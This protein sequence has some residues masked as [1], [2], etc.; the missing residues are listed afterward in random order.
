MKSSRQFQ[1]THPR[2]VR[3]KTGVAVGR[4][5]G[6]F[7]S[8]TLVG[9]DIPQVPIAGSMFKFQFTHPHGVLRSG[10]R[11]QVGV[12]RFQ[13]T[14]PRGVR[15]GASLI[16]SLTPTVSI[17]APSWGATRP[18]GTQIV[19]RSFQFTHPRGVRLVRSA[20]S[21]ER[22]CFN[23]RTHVGCDRRLRASAGP[24]GRFN[25]RTHVGCD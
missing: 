12:C 17:H 9:C 2:G 6:R 15:R 21:E 23:S 1:F 13:F 5:Y 25:S 7:N 16:R 20:G 11:S 19:S 18:H 22:I 3:R 10:L 14:H 4:W 8:R 24:E